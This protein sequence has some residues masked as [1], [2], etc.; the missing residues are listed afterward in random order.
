M[1]QK[2]ASTQNFPT[3]TMLESI[4]YMDADDELG[5]IFNHL[6]QNTGHLGDID[7]G[8]IKFLYGNK[9]KK[10]GGRY[11]IGYLMARGIL[12]KTVVPQYDYIVVVYY[13]IWKDL[14]NESKS[15]H[16]DKILCGIH[17]EQDKN[18]N[19]IAKKM[20]TDS[21]EYYDNMRYWGADKVLKQSEAMHL[22]I[23]SK[24][25]DIK[26]KN[27]EKKKNEQGKSV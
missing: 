12:E 2:F 10:D 5:L 15:L 17:V 27:K 25:E 19:E 8:R 1:D 16:L 7:R 6:K 24:I 11:I 9:P 26:S 14:D 3:P 18:G 13:P 23:T 21:R 22:A 20:P 4:E